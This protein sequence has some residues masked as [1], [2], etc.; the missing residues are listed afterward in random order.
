MKGSYIFL[1]E[2]ILYCDGC[3]KLVRATKK[4]QTDKDESLA[5]VSAAVCQ[6]TTN[7]SN[8]DTKL[9]FESDGKGTRSCIVDQISAFSNNFQQLSS[10]LS[11]VKRNL[12]MFVSTSTVI[13]C[14]YISPV[15][16][17]IMGDLSTL[18]ALSRRDILS[19]LNI[20][21]ST[22]PSAEINS[23]RTGTSAKWTARS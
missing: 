19:R 17:A 21:S 4:W 8:R 11:Y 5:K 6:R 18:K 23:R 15:C 2:L 14:N 9:Q 3:E 1:Y 16:L 10:T 13:V 12:A 20:L 22:N 7:L